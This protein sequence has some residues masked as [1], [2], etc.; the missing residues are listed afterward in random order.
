MSP[1]HAIRYRLGVPIVFFAGVGL[2]ESVVFFLWGQLIG[3]D[4]EKGA[5]IHSDKTRAQTFYLVRNAITRLTSWSW[6][7]NDY[8]GIK[9]T[10]NIRKYL[11]F[12]LFHNIV[13][14]QDFNQ[15]IEKV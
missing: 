12:P 8:C 7:I 5:A 14:K 4:R 15:I 6:R 9:L 13:S 3:E 1:T 10:N 2:G 11:G